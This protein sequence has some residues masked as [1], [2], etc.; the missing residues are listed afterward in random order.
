MTGVPAALRP[1]PRKQRKRNAKN[2]MKTP[3]T[4]KAVGVE[5]GGAGAIADDGSGR[6]DESVEED[7]P[8]SV[9]DG[10][11]SETKIGSRRRPP[12]SAHK[13]WRGKMEAAT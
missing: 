3:L 12:K 10:N 1:R 6:F 2:Q 8:C 9:D 5:A 4:A 11:A 7:V 13:R